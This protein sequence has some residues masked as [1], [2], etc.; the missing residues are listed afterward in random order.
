[1]VLVALAAAVLVTLHYVEFEWSD[2]PRILER[3]N[4]PLALVIMATLP[5]VGF[6][7][8][9]VYLA[10]GAIFGPGWGGLV[11]AA[12][13]VIHVTA[14]QLLART[15]LRGH[16]ARWHAMLAKRLPALTK[17]DNISLA[18]MI[19]LVP[20]LPYIARNCLLAV[21][22]VPLRYIYLVAV[23]L[24]IARSY[25]TLFLG[26]VGNDP[27]IKTLAIIGT[28]F[29]VKLG[30]SA[31]LFKRLRDQA[32]HV[33]VSPRTRH[34]NAAAEDPAGKLRRSSSRPPIVLKEMNVPPPHLS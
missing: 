23:P 4:R 18:A 20:G 8:S 11:V 29:V 24:Y 16:V 25:T 30:I 7:I 15:L 17:G 13:T 19:V 2:V 31:L 22:E 21:S 1:M 28:I 33:E 27:S 34:G 3:V 10:T 9:A 32:K 6:P 5:I 14:T 12:I 26:N